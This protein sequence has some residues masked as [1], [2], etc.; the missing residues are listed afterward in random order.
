M[1]VVY[2]ASQGLQYVH[3]VMHK[4]IMARYGGKR[5]TH[6]ACKKH[7]HLTKTEGNFEK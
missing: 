6:K 1:V 2:I 5:K 3:C 7:I 4:C